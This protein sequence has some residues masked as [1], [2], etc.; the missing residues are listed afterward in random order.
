MNIDN[1]RHDNE[2]YDGM[3]TRRA[4]LGLAAFAPS[5]FLPGMSALAET[6]KDQNQPAASSEQAYSLL[7][8]ALIQVLPVAGYQTR[9]QLKDCIIKLV[10]R[11]VIDP[12]KFEAL[13]ESG[14]TKPDEFKT[15]LS[16]RSDRRIP[17][18]R[19]NASFYVNLLWPVGLS[20]HMKSNARSPIN[21]DSLFSFASTGGWN[22]GK[23]P[24]G[25]SYFNKFDIVA[26]KPEQEDL[27]TKIAESTYRP[28]CNNS[29]FFQDCNH[30][31]ALLGMLQLGASQGLNE[32]ELYQEALAFNSF[33]FADTYVQTALYFKIFENTE[34]KDV[35]PVKVMGFDY[36]AISPWQEN[37]AARLAT[38]PNLFPPPEG[39]VKCGT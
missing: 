6:L 38:I 10:A 21:G 33:W 29:T 16:E 2:H 15:I 14:A 34:W 13:Y 19:N 7:N 1:L 36:S 39:G 20:N 37:V 3:K 4:F 11:G 26:L 27:V 9:I 31:S 22:I 5:V 18:T 25:G 23:K 12:K 24:N 28:C 35:D 32:K 17:L 8:E 30:G